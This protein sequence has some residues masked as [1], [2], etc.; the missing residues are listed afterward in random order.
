MDIGGKTA[1]ATGGGRLV[2]VAN[3]LSN[4]PEQADRRIETQKNEEPS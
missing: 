4:W 2:G 1:V 3:G